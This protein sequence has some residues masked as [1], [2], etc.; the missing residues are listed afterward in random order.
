MKPDTM[1]LETRAVRLAQMEELVGKAMEFTEERERLGLADAMDVVRGV[2]YPAALESQALRQIANAVLHRR[3]AKTAE[4]NGSEDPHTATELRER[5]ARLLT[6]YP[7]LTARE[8]WDWMVAEHG[9]PEVSY[10][11]FEVHYWSKLRKELVRRKTIPDYY[12]IGFEAYAS[13]PPDADPPQRV[14]AGKGHK[15][16]KPKKRDGV[17]PYAFLV[18]RGS[19]EVRAWEVGDKG[20][21]Q[22]QLRLVGTREEADALLAVVT[23]ILM[24]GETDGTPG[25][26]PA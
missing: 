20:D 18:R 19:G 12:P 23:D 26:D 9:E 5:V 16:S 4:Q 8:G 24:R 14:P 13:A 21:V 2:A 7:A 22:V 1:T 15:I 3:R 6:Q 10:R 11:T 17:D 25:S